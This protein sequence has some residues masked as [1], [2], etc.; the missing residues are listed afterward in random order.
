MSTLHLTEAR[1]WIADCYWG[2]RLDWYPESLTDE[3]VIRG[4]ERHYTGGWERFVN[5]IEN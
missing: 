1:L 5:D 4:I 2:D 3:D